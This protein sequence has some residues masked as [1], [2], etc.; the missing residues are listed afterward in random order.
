MSTGS[1]DA[2]DFPYSYYVIE[3][4]GYQGKTVKDDL[5]LDSCEAVG[6]CMMMKTDDFYSLKTDYQSLKL[7]L[8]NR[9]LA[10][11]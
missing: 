9:E 8:I 3:P 10:N 5:G 6:S 4:N 2:P 7:K 11:P 1:A